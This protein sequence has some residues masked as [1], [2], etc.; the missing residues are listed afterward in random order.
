[1]GNVGD[2]GK[3]VDRDSTRPCSIARQVGRYDVREPGYGHSQLSSN[4]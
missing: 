1:M 4:I 2:I 3:I